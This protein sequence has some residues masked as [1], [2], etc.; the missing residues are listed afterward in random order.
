MP[1]ETTTITYEPGDTVRLNS[2]GPVM[3]VTSVAGEA[4]CQLV[5]CCWFDDNDCLCES[6]I[7]ARAVHTSSERGQ[8]N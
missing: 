5:L 7:P 1:R 4:H 3:T 6:L 2:G 8:L